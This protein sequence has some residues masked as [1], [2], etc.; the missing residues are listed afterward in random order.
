MSGALR[1][2]CFWGSWVIICAARCCPEN[3]SDQ[4]SGPISIKLLGICWKRGCGEEVAPLNYF[5]ISQKEVGGIGSIL[6]LP[7]CVR[8]RRWGSFQWLDATKISAGFRPNSSVWADLR[9]AASGRLAAARLATDNRPKQRSRAALLP[10]DP[11][12]LRGWKSVETS[13]E[14]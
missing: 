11:S 4:K 6:D 12:P 9:P 1:T 2:R 3:L 7:A 5:L 14:K 10:Y 13:C 8:L